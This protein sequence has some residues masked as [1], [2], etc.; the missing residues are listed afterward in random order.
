MKAGVVEVM[1][2]DSSGVGYLD[3]DKSVIGNKGE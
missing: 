2:T 1:A 3:M